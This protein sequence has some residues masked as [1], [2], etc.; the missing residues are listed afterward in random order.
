[1]HYSGLHTV[2]IKKTS[3]DGTEGVE[4]FQPWKG[5]NNSYSVKR[6]ALNQD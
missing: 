1:M 3:A 4:Q 6:D 2:V 5:I